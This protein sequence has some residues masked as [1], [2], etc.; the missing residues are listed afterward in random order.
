MTLSLLVLGPFELLWHE[1]PLQFATNPARALLAYLAVEPERAHARELL[2]A[3]LWPDQ[4]QATAYTNLRQTLARVRKAF[5]AEAALAACLTITPYT[6]Q[7]NRAALSSDLVRFDALLAACAAH[8]HPD[9]STCQACLDRLQQA[10]LLYRGEFLQGFFLPHSQPFEE[11][12]LLKR[13][14]LHRQALDLFSTLTHAFEAAGDYGQMCH[15]A[16]RQLALE[17][18]RST[19]H[20]AVYCSRNWALNQRSKRGSYTSVFR[21]V[22]FHRCGWLLLLLRRIC[23]RN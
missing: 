3:L 21:L 11:W 14:M 2:A 4:P 10:A 8:A 5:P 18:W 6:V 19:T 1:Q 12:L 16:A 15:Y 9:R 22:S 7:F 20:A 13:E 17:P 23:R